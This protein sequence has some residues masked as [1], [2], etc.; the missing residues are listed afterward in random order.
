MRPDALNA[1][2]RA[3]AMAGLLLS[4][5]AC[6]RPADL[7]YRAPA[8]VWPAAAVPFIADVVVVD[9]RDVPP[10]YVGAVMGFDGKPL[11]RLHSSEPVA[12][13]VRN[14]FRSALAAR[15]EL[16]PPGTTARD[17]SYVLTVTL[18]QL[19]AE[20]NA[21]RQGEADMVVRLI[22]R[23]TGRE[24]YSARTYTEHRGDNYLAYDNLLLGS[25][26][27]LSGV[28]REVLGRAVNET[29]DREGFRRALREVS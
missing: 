15:G 7:W 11:K 12:E 25:P 24:A 4:G 28:A 17:A 14:A 8:G 10:S 9:E 5:A 18:L 27:A 20:Q 23:T 13:A 1:T 6:T 29:V 19:N 16:A 21:D 3:L 2:A 26:A 22:D